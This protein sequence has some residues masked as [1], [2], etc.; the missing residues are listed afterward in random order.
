MSYRIVIA[1]K[2][3]PCSAKVVL[4]NEGPGF[5]ATKEHC[6][7]PSKP[8]PS[9]IYPF[10]EKMTSRRKNRMMLRPALR[11]Y[12]KTPPLDAAQGVIKQFILHHD[13]C[14]SAKTCF[15]VLHNE[16]G[17]SCHFLMDNDGTLYQTM[18]LAYMGF[19]AAGFNS[20]SVGIELCNRGDA[21][22]Y[23]GY[24]NR[25]DPDRGATTCR[26]HDY[27]Y[28]A[29]KYTDAQ[30]EA[31]YGLAEALARALPNCPIEYPQDPAKPGQAAW[32]QIPNA[33][34]FAGYLGHYHTTTRK[35]DPGPFDFKE[36]CEK[37]RGARCFPVWA[38]E[39]GDRMTRPQIP[40]QSDLL[41]DKADELIALNERAEGGFF[42]VGPYRGDDERRDSR[43]WH[44]G[45]H[46]QHPHRGAIVYA[47]FPGRLM[48]ARMGS[49]SAVGSTNFALLRHDMAIGQHSVRFFSLYF[50]LDD[51]RGKE[52]DADAPDWA[53][54]D[55]WQRQQSSP[56]PALLNEP[57]E[58]GDVIG[59][60]GLGGPD[61]YQQPQIHFEVFAS[62]NIMNR[63]QPGRWPTVD[64]TAGGRF[65]AEARILDPIDTDRDGRLSRR[66]LLSYF[67]GNPDAALTRNYVTQHTSEWTA[68][69]DWREALRLSPEFKDMNEDDIDDLVEEQIEPTLWWDKRVANH[70]GLP[71]DGVVY[72]FHPIQFVRQVNEELLITQALGGIGSWKESEAK[73]AGDNVTDDI[74]DET[75]ESFVTEAELTEEVEENIFLEDMV[76]GFTDE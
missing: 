46:L 35:W 28:Y 14:P 69:P 61:G 73:A 58:A 4:W 72:H 52:K 75:G 21:K 63:I 68:H 70:A 9:G 32:G 47:P 27:I 42:P 60:V 24:Y 2:E 49:P 74:A 64:G 53:K 10:S 43:L 67:V 19:H 36:F 38:K 45:V 18:D 6:I 29:Y 65:S 62:D 51:E 30:M 16:R 25:S 13:G 3:I 57:V 59:R 41:A 33:A 40:N 20:Q 26:I 5:D 39:K 55:D 37:A 54:S 8:C 11:R 7:N 15:N 71:R 56:L 12:G 1:N 34:N 22:K 44:G 50:H 76:Q 31:M 17:L 23:P 48:V 66:E